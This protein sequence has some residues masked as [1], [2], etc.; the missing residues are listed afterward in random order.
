MFAAPPA[1][2]RQHGAGRR[3]RRARPP[4]P[5][6]KSSEPRACT[7]RPAR[8]RPRQASL[9]TDK[10]ALFPRSAFVIGYDTAVRLVAPRYYGRPGGPAGEDAAEMLLQV[11]IMRACFCFWRRVCLPQDCLAARVA[12]SASS[13][14]WPR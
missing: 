12:S 4:L 2:S 11:R 14:L 13:L 9:F 10:A 8:A 7:E 3:G 5:E 1:C 6:A